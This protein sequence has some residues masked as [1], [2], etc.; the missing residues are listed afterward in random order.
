MHVPSRPTEADIKRRR[1]SAAGNRLIGAIF[2]DRYEI[3][4]HLGSGGMAD[5]YEGHDRMLK[6]DVA[7]KILRDDSSNDEIAAKRLQREARAAG[8]LHH[9]HIITFHDVGM[10][11]G[12]LFIVM[13]KLIGRTLGAEREVVGGRMPALRAC[14][15]GAQISAALRCVHSAN[16]VH[17]DLKPDNVYMMNRGAN[18]WIKLLDFSIAKLPEELIDGRLTQTGTIFGTPYYMAPEQAMGDPVCFQTDLYA[19]GA[20]LFELVTGRPPFLADNAIKLLAKQSLETAPRISSTGV[21]VPAALDDLVE[22]MLEKVPWHRPATA[23]DVQVL[24]ESIVEMGDEGTVASSRDRARKKRRLGG[25]GDVTQQG[26][27]GNTVGGPVRS[28]SAVYQAVSELERPITVRSSSPNLKKRPPPAPL[29]PPPRGTLETEPMMMPGYERQHN[30]PKPSGPPPRKV[31]KHRET[32]PRTTG[33]GMRR[34]RP[35]MPS[36]QPANGDPD[37]DGKDGKDSKDSKDSK[38]GKDSAIDEDETL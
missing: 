27:F 35:T 23:S 31:R 17:R 15:I 30:V 2:A 9:P 20:M 34:G 24:L 25:V 37:E 38:G 8:Q 33:G 32:Q 10:V 5:V 18:D 13:E 21:R 12:R 1:T 14:R 16:I 26:Q 22:S 19:L 7:I 36:W 6:R 28:P 4:G 3:V 29:H 11:D